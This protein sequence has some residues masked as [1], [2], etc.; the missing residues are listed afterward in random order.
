MLLAKYKKVFI[1]IGIS[2]L[3]LTIV[4]A[5][6]LGANSNIRPSKASAYTMVLNANN[7]PTLS[8]GE[9]TMVDEKN[10]TWEYH[11]A[12]D[13]NNGHVSIGHQGYFG[14]SSSTIYGYTSISE[15]TVNFTVGTN[16]ELWLLTSIDGIDWNERIKLTS[17]EN[18]DYAN[19][20]RYIRFY[21]WDDDN[22]SI[23][24][25][26]VNF[27]YECSGISSSE[28]IDI[29]TYDGIASTSNLTAARETSIVSPLGN[30]QESVYLTRTANGSYCEFYLKENR[31]I[32]DY[33]TY[34]I[35]FDFYH[36]NNQNKPSVQFFNGTKSVGG[37]ATY[38]SKKSYYKFSDINSDWWHIEI[39][40]TA[41]VV[42][43]VSHSD[44]ATAN[45]PMDRIRITTGNCAIDNLRIDCTPSDANHPLGI[46]NNGTSFGHGGYY[47]MKVSWSGYLHSC[48]FTYDVPG[49]VEQ[50]IGANHPFYLYGLQA[51]TVVV[52]A[53]LVV[54]YCRNSVTISN[55]I[56]V[57]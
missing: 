56:T 22:N 15:L 27:G 33:H 47:W 10:V 40:I 49:I 24:V 32:F 16:G 18:T 34:E 30:S 53:H 8:N 4:E 9:G 6:F 5:V 39:H 25:T 35:E 7:A 23:D 3:P 26:S 12:S 21:C 43:A 20:W 52:T 48:T 51:G 31:K 55:T 2:V 50:E 19:N 1:A 14:V 36:K 45:N 28:D 46:Y 57:S 41:F 42:P 17:G 13:L 37:S 11:N 38:E 44:H 29:A 54:G